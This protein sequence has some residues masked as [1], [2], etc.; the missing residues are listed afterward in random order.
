MSAKVR[1]SPDAR[2]AQLLELGVRIFSERPYDDLSMD[3][4]A[5]LAGV[6]KGLLYHYFPTKRAFYVASLA[7][8]ADGIAK[9]IRTGPRQR[10]GRHLRQSIDAFLGFVQDHRAIFQAV[11]G[12]GIGSDPEVAAVADRVRDAAYSVIVETAPGLP[13]MSARLRVA[14]RGWVGL[15]EAA[16]MEWVERPGMAR[17]DLVELLVQS[18]ASLVQASHRAAPVG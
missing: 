1:L 8:I 4:I 12:A 5:E 11:R 9:M 2:R 10:T 15:V 14:I 13:E 3:R 16:S 17:E 18:L 7:E 6:S